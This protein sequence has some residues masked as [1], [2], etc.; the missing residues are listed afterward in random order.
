MSYALS[1]ELVQS[2]VI[3]QLLRHFYQLSVQFSY[4]VKDLVYPQGICITTEKIRQLH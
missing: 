1:I 3:I 4:G 2:T